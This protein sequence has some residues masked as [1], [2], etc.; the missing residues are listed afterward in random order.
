MP[1]RA[2]RP[3]V[4]PS[5][6]RILC[7]GLSCVDNIWLVD[8]FPPRASRTDASGYRLQG[9]GPAATA[10]AAVARLGGTAHLWALHGD[11][12][13]GAAALAE[14]ERMGVD[15]GG[16]QRQPGAVSWVSSV[17][18]EPDGERWIFPYRGSNLIDRPPERPWPENIDAVLVDLRHERLCEAALD[19]A[20]EVGAVTVGDVSNTR[21]WHLT[22]QLDVLIASEECARE[23]AGSGDEEGWPQALRSFEGQ[24]VGVTLGPRGYLWDEGDGLERAPAFPVEAVDTTGA[25]DVFHGAYAF[26]LGLGLSHRECAAFAQ[27]TAALSCLGLGRSALPDREQI[28]EFLLERGATVSGVTGRAGGD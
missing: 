14:L 6:P 18:V 16:V 11:D 19:W 28:E 20:R 27:A 22:G 25:G 7:A 13:A 3:A 23:V 17:L 8:E 4:K 15:L 26:A 5:Q 24:V 2:T 21:H 10:A 9:G 12:P 1:R